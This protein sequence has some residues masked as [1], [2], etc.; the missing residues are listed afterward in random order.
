MKR[1][2]LTGGG[3][4]IVDDEDFDTLSRHRW[5]RH[6]QGYACRSSWA[7]GKYV[8]ILMHRVVA[9]APDG[10][11]VD[12]LDLDKLNNTRANLRVV[13]RAT[14]ERNKPPSRRN[15]SGVKGVSF[16]ASRG[17]WKAAT[18][19]RGRQYTI[20]RFATIEEAQ[21]AYAEFVL[22]IT[23]EEVRWPTSVCPPVAAALVRANAASVATTANNNAERGAA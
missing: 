9:R 23:G 11:Q 18:K 21:R 16:D 17:K 20:G 12:H 19:H 5:K 8:C 14:N 13:D 2:Q 7:H 22:S 10:L 4:A 3:A 1:I 15:K 6:P